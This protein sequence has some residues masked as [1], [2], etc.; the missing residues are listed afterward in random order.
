[1]ARQPPREAAPARRSDS[2]G[3]M[4][5]ALRVRQS[6]WVAPPRPYPPSADS[7]LPRGSGRGCHPSC[8]RHVAAGHPLELSRKSPLEGALLPASRM[9]GG[10]AVEAGSTRLPADIWL[11]RG[12]GRQLPAVGSSSGFAQDTCIRAAEEWWRRNRPA[13]PNAMIH[14][15]I[16]SP[17][18]QSSSHQPPPVGLLHQPRYASLRLPG[19][20]GTHAPAPPSFSA[21]SRR[22][23]TQVSQE[24][25]GGSR[26]IDQ[27]GRD[28]ATRAATSHCDDQGRRSRAEAAAA[29]LGALLPQGD[30]LQRRA[31]SAGAYSEREYPF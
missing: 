28:P 10:G 11:T 24:S 15:L 8:V 27:E 12:S 29:R 25:R 6:G 5:F 17:H 1:M 21:R 16:S 14:P 26:R 23:D 2:L 4:Q 13:A 3:Q 19:L 30:V 7:W 20:A 22:L 9:S 18:N 31:H